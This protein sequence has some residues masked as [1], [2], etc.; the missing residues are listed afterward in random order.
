MYV[1][2]MARDVDPDGSAFIWVR[3]SGSIFQMRILIQRVY[4]KGKIKSLTNNIFSFAGIKTRIYTGN[5]NLLGL[6][7]DLKILSIFDFLKNLVIF[8]PGSGYDQC[9][10]TSLK[11]SIHTSSTWQN[12][13]KCGKE[14]KGDREGRRGSL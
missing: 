10:S 5:F 12:I 9:G 8:C 7:S 11:A 4:N 1:V 3:G 13:Y 14:K 6:G 2:F